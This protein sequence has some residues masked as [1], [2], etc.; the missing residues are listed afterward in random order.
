MKRFEFSE[1]RLRDCVNANK[2][3]L[4]RIKQRICCS[5]EAER[6]VNFNLASRQMKEYMRVSSISKGQQYST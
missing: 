6:T 5:V 1:I 2:T 4:E 3:V